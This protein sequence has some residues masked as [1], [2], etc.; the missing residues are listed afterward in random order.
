MSSEAGT[1]RLIPILYAALWNSGCCCLCYPVL[2]RGLRFDGLVAVWL[3]GC[4][5]LAGFG[6]KGY[7]AIAIFFLGTI[8][9]VYGF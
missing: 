3:L 8:G 6:W 4:L 5:L 2:R 7:I 1:E 9:H